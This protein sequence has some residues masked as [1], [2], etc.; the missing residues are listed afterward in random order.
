M[1][2]TKGKGTTST[3][4]AKLLE[5]E[6]KKV[7]L[8]GNIGNSPLDFVTK[9]QPDDWVV[10]ELSNFQLYNFPY[11]PHIAVCLMIT[12]EHL[13]WHPSFE[14]YL[15]AKAGIFKHQNPE[16]IAI[17][18]AK[19]ENSK[20]IAAVSPGRK[21]SYFEKPGAYVRSDGMIVIGEGG[22]E[23]IPKSEVRLLGEHNLQNVC[24]AL[25]AVS[26]ALGNLDNAQKVLSSF[27][28]LEH[29]LELVREFERVK[30]YDDS[31]ATTPDS[32]V[33]ALRTFKEPKIVILGGSN[34]GLTFEPLADEVAKSKV[35]HAIIIGDTADKISRLLTERGFT[36]ITLGLT[37]MTD[38][39]ETAR[40]LAQPGDIVLLSTAC[41]SFGLFKDYKDRGNQF[42]AAVKALS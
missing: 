7:F 27:S 25:T 12:Q 29:R 35:R 40:K 23:I 15:S 20:K 28:G 26:E 11:S 21:V 38:I 4:I 37:K 13:D 18:F 9:V 19:D 41:A 8:G 32:T 3:L 6:G 39:V 42:K 31:F 30:Y 5:A 14:D 33:V 34:K 16:D 10:L 36:D 17:Y 2:G 1:T 22:K 24:A